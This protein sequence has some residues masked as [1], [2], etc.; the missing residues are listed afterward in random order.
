VKAKSPVKTSVIAKNAVPPPSLMPNS[1]KSLSG[2]A[3][4]LSVQAALKAQLNLPAHPPAAEA[5]SAASAASLLEVKSES[6]AYIDS[7]RLMNILKTTEILFV[8]VLNIDGRRKLEAGESCTDQRK[9][10]R[11]V[12]INRNFPDWF[13]PNNAR[14]SEEDYQGPAP[15]SEWETNIV[16]SLAD[17]FKP[18][19]FIDIHSG[20]LGM[21]YVWGHSGR[22]LSP[23][24]DLNR[25]W[26]RAVESEVFGGKV[27]TG[28]LANMGNMPYE[29]HGSSCDYMY[30]TQG[31]RIAGT[32][33]IWRKASFFGHADNNAVMADAA[34]KYDHVSS[35]SSMNLKSQII[36]GENFNSLPNALQVDTVTT[37]PLSMAET[38][39]LMQS[40]LGSSEFSDSLGLG[41]DEVSEL[42]QSMKSEGKALSEIQTLLQD[43][44][45]EQCFFYFNPVMPDQYD[46]TVQAFAKAILIGAEKLSD[47]SFS[48]KLSRR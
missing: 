10:G 33:E 13:N 46:S 1:P 34:K 18:H 24:D 38:Q 23:D 35:S 40:A 30:Q 27:W 3:E 28:N 36:E 21:G 2:D 48:A 44:S 4:I 42:I 7:A 26:V 17:Q 19:A 11:N 43:M 47:P 9:N 8:P 31:A 6:K 15:M 32:W 37:S 12:D 14:Q 39:S 41:R 29:S 16:K 45:R 20:D 5:A 25:N 22:D